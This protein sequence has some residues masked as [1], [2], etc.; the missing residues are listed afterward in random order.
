MVYRYCLE[1][2]KSVGITLT[3]VLYF[4]ICFG[5][6]DSSIVAVTKWKTVK[7]ASGIRLRSSSYHQSLFRSN[8]QINILEI[9]PGKKYRLD[10]EAEVKRLKP[11]SE[12]G[13]AVNAIAALNGTFFDTKNGGSMDYIRID[14]AVVSPNRLQANNIRA[15]HQKAAITFDEGRIANASKKNSSVRSAEKYRQVLKC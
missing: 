5:Q 1:R 4:G 11:T 7:I 6:S 8:Q 12:F 15:L 2:L 3:V 10:V 14:G 9:S 13:A